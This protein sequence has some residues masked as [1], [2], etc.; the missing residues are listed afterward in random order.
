MAEKNIFHVISDTIR[1]IDN[2]CILIGGY[3]V[4][5]YHITRQTADIDFIVTQADY[6]KILPLLQSLGFH[7]SYRQDVFVRLRA[8]K[9]DYLTDLDFIEPIYWTTYRIT[10]K[11]G[12]CLLFY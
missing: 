1:Q 12:S 3:A 7:E 9:E 2:R 4:N 11:H 8:E 5:Y 10:G 6:D